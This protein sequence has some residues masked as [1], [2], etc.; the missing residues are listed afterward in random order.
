MKSLQL[1]FIMTPLA[2]LLAQTPPAPQPPTMAVKPP[3]VPVMPA[4]PAVPPETVVLTIGDEKVTAAEFDHMIEGLPP[5]YRNQMRGAGKRQFADNVV[6]LKMLS[7][8]AHSHK[9][10]ESPAFKEQLAT[11][12]ERLLAQQYYQQLVSNTKVDEATAREYYE[13][14]KTDY[15]QAK[16]RQIL[17]RA[18][19]SP[20]A[21]KKDAKELTDEEALAKAK[22]VRQKLVDG[23]DFV[24]LAK[25]D[26]DDTITSANG[27]DLGT[28]GHNRLPPAVDQVVF[29]IAVGELS[30][31]IKSPQGYHII[32]VETRQEKT[33]VDV[34]PEIERKLNAD[35]VKKTM[36]DLKTS[37]NVVFNA[38][39]FGPATPPPAPMK[40]TISVQPKPDA[41]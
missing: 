36:D 2:C 40:P 7:Q 41:K 1:L 35:L 16:V 14:H 24:A 11:Q 13:Q 33:F 10:D 9:V 31:P 27:G 38:D 26:S 12:V 6:M 15:L 34:K 17:I 32:K 5:Q 29:T 23:G 8:E 21:L 25:I 22:E 28:I 18:K 37:K 20:V 4:T 3:A 19:G 39:Y 30:E